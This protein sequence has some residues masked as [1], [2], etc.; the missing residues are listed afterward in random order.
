MFALAS[1]CSARARNARLRICPSPGSGHRA[2][3]D[4]EVQPLPGAG[5]GDRRVDDV[6]AA[7]ARAEV[8]AADALHAAL[9]DAGQRLPLDPELRRLVGADLDDQRLD[10]NL[11]AADVELFDDRAQVV[12]DGLGRLDDQRIVRGVGLDGDAARGKADRA[13]APAAAGQWR[14]AGHDVGDRAGDTAA[15]GRGQRACALRHDV[16]AAREQRAQRLRNPCRL[17]VLE[18]DDED[19]AAGAPRR[20]ELLDQ[21]AHARDAAAVVGTH[22][23][24]VR[25]R[26]GDQRHALLRVGRSSGGGFGGEP[27][28]DRHQ[29]ERRGILD[30]NDGRLAGG[31]LVERGSRCGR[32]AFRFSA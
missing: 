27:V 26:I 7:A 9:A 20:V 17:R 23:D 14:R 6:A 11:G 13:A 10:V 29:V 25:A 2:V 21:L 4:A 28:E 24:A 32:S 19:V 5:E 18:V 1:V 8:G 15:G 3:D 30:R 22:D 31:R 12:V 16:A